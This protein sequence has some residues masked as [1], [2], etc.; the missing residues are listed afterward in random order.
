MNKITQALMRKIIRKSIHQSRNNNLYIINHL[1]VAPS[2]VK[3]H[4][5]IG[6]NIIHEVNKTKFAHFRT[7]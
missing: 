1:Q 4:E 7:A 6:L 2:D 3:V 5:K